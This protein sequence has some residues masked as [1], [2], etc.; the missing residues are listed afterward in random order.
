MPPSA[1]D[2]P[3]PPDLS[4][5]LLAE[6]DWIRRLAARM[7]GQGS[8]NDDD[9]DDLTQTVVAAA[10]DQQPAVQPTRGIRNWISM[11]TKRQASR[12]RQRAHRR[13]EAETVAHSMRP[14]EQSEP[15]EIVER[16]QLHKRLTNYVLELPEPYRSLIVARFLEE[17]SIHE[18][19]N[20]RGAK[21]ATVRQQLHRAVAKLRARFEREEGRDGRARLALL[22]GGP[23]AP[24]STTAL[25]PTAL[26]AMTTTTKTTLALCG[27]A[28]ALVILIV[29]V[30]P[31]GRGDPTSDPAASPDVA[32]A[33]LDSRT[34]RPGETAPETTVD[35]Q[36]VDPQAEPAPLTL[37]V[38]DVAAAAVVDATVAVVPNTRP[39]GLDE[40]AIGTTDADG[41][42][43]LGVLA[44][45]TERTWH[46]LVTA[47]GRIVSW[48]ELAPPASGGV[49][50][51]TLP[52]AGRIEG[53]V[54]PIGSPDALGAEHGARPAMLFLSGDGENPFTGLPSSLQQ[55]LR[56]T[57]LNWRQHATA[58]VD[59]NTGRFSFVGLPDGDASYTVGLP[60]G[61]PF[62]VHPTATRPGKPS[63]EEVRLPVNTLDAVIAVVPVP[64]VRG[65]V[66]LSDGEPASF[67][68]VSTRAWLVDDDGPQSFATADAEGRFCS[69]LS[70]DAIPMHRWLD[71]AEQPRVVRV[72]FM[73]VSHPAAVSKPR[74]RYSFPTNTRWADVGDIVLERLDE[75]PV[76]VTS[77]GGDPVVSAVL[78]GAKHS[79]PTG[80]DG[81]TTVFVRD[82][83]RRAFRIGAAGWMVDEYRSTGGSGT[84]DD[85]LR[86]ALAP[87][88]R[89]AVDF[90]SEH[91]DPSEVSLEIDAPKELFHGTGER[92]AIMPTRLHRHAGS[93]R[94]SSGDNRKHSTR[95]TRKARFDDNGTFA[96]ASLIPNQS[97]TFT[98][99]DKGGRVLAEAEVTTPAL[100]ETLAVDLRPTVPLCRID[101][102]ILTANGEPAPKVHVTVGGEHR[103]GSSIHTPR[104]R[105]NAAGRVRF[106]LRATGD[107]V[108]FRIEAADHAVST[109]E[110]RLVEGGTTPVFHLERGYHVIAKVVDE[111][112]ARIDAEVGVY[113]RNVGAR[114]ERL[115]N[116]DTRV[117]RLPGQEVELVTSYGCRNFRKRVT[118]KASKT[119]VTIEVPPALSIPIR[120]APHVAQD[121]VLTLSVRTADGR[122]RSYSQVHYV[123]GLWQPSTLAIYPGSYRVRCGAYAGDDDW[124]TTWTITEGDAKPR[125]LMQ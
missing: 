38:Q 83:D 64:A 60:F 82:V 56:S 37:R 119:T 114:I 58:H 10:L 89:I 49:V 35:R 73:G 125:W 19:A 94:F 36:A 44:E 15:S 26:A 27:T 54:E 40:V 108:P 14:P 68:E 77:P 95:S 78:A 118:P 1:S 102:K 23:A 12:F 57:G 84:P 42:C 75:L 7:L 45:P 55:R 62:L 91:L 100:G 43:D 117:E 6:Y 16:L 61:E 46:L 30:D 122:A 109:H 111:S 99:L 18:I 32:T 52:D 120:V 41:R 110:I 113:D 90:E 112:G 74:M 65:R 22:C 34:S 47:P 69:R 121:T 101:A 5:E 104:G 11:V 72:D 80:T 85:P 71:A 86:F 63:R 92:I 33:E 25:V 29:T 123:D 24:A 59:P 96:I 3:Q 8:A 2:P 50:T 48:R 21:Q 105:T 87:E 98:V 4:A 66:V 20:A 13:G 28:L 53:I 107:T 70:I 103:R 17:R 106:R 67:A 79:P 31:G 124:E 76:L 97:V 51:V 93:G 115:P 9:V 116:G 81:R 39:L 88:N